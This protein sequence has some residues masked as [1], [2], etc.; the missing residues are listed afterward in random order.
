MFQQWLDLIDAGTFDPATT[1]FCEM[2]T[3][4]AETLRQEWGGKFHF[5]EVKTFHFTIRIVKVWKK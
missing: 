2:M 4:Q 3:R 5:E 1:F